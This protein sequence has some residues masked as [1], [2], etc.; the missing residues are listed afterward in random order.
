MCK[1]F[2]C[3]IVTFTITCGGLVTLYI[4]FFDTLAGNAVVMK[5]RNV[6]WLNG[7]ELNV[8]RS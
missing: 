8:G 6:Y 1:S 4:T 2:D 7:I 3:K 5:K